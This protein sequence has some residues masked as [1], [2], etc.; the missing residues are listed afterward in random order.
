M[1]SLTSAPPAT[2]ELRP[3]PIPQESEEP[4]VDGQSHPRSGR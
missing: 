4:L 1:N 2:Q 3:L